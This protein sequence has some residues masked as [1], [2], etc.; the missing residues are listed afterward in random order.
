MVDYMYPMPSIAVGN[1]PG[2]Q[3]P[4]KGSD[5]ENTAIS[6]IRGFAFER[7]NPMDVARESDQSLQEVSGHA[8][9]SRYRY[10]SHVTP[11]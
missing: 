10:P 9:T 4:S 6:L 8:V 7:G 3:Q 2:A 5:K 11:Y 1:I